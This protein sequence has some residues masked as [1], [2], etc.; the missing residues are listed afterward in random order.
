MAAITDDLAERAIRKKVAQIGTAA[1]NTRAQAGGRP[2][3]PTV[4]TASQSEFDEA[5]RALRN[6]VPRVQ[7]QS[8][9]AGLAPAEAVPVADLSP[10]ER[11]SFQRANPSGLQTAA[12]AEI[13]AAQA[14]TNAKLAVPTATPSTA[15]PGAVQPGVIQPAVTA[16]GRI[17]RTAGAIARNPLVRYGGKALGVAEGLLTAGEGAGDIARSGAGIKNVAD[18]GAG[19]ALTAG[20]LGIGGAVAAPLLA[21]A[22]GGY[23]AGKLISDKIGAKG[24]FIGQGVDRLVKLFGGEGADD[25]TQSRDAARAAGFAATKANPAARAAQPGITA[26]LVPV[27]D[28]DGITPPAERDPNNPNDVLGT[29]NGRPIT[30]G[31]SDKLSASNGLVGNAASGAT[32]APAA[33]SYTPSISSDI[34]QAA[35]DK[36][37]ADLTQGVGP[38]G[39][40]YKQLLQDKTPTGKRVAA[41]FAADY[42]GQG[43]SEVNARAGLE[44]DR[45]NAEAGLEQSREGNT[46]AAAREAASRGERRQY[47]TG[48]EGEVSSIS[49]GVLS[50]VLGPDGKP[51]KVS[52]SSKAADPIEQRTKFE[53]LVTASI[54]TLNDFAG[55]PEE[56][57]ALRAKKSRELLD[58]LLGSAEDKAKA[59][60]KDKTGG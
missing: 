24:E 28:E 54:G 29:F 22:G 56:Y 33:P 38:A 36:R 21:S 16:P 27:V 17:A 34:G 18:V 41:Q 32:T 23:V 14:A 7:P 12:Q 35:R 3:L 9:S 53:A 19:G 13:K 8:I 2:P 59:K 5:R 6:K 11:A 10:A 51:A 52:K 25:S 37:V 26:D 60:A 44:G 55:S 46:S 20:S 31:E 1:A 42:M 45:L 30:R 47:I 4:G 58:E 49:D 15:I 40:H 50:P 48:D 57:Q 39:A 43:T